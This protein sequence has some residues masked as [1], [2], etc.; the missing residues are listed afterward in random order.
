MSVLLL[1]DW[2]QH[3]TIM[4]FNRTE[5]DILTDALQH[6]IET[7]SD[8]KLNEEEKTMIRNLIQKILANC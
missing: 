7:A 4:K 3:I 2:G 1:A 8:P 6:W 5:I